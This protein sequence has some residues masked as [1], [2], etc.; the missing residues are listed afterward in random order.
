MPASLEAKS[1][2]I[3]LKPALYD[4]ATRCAKLKGSS[5][6]SLVQ[7]GLENIIRAQEEQ[8]MHDA[9][10]LLSMDPEGCDVQYAF[11]AQ[12]EAALRNE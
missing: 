2:S 11:A 10:K 8:E 4:A 12:A 5:L 3:R 9:A 1:L 6:N 7:Q